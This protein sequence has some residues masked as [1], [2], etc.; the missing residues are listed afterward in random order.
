MALQAY[1]S[2][3]SALTRREQQKLQAVY[4]LHFFLSAYPGLMS[5]QRLA[6]GHQVLTTGNSKASSV[7]A[8]TWLKK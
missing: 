6:V 8:R 2:L 7:N 1:Y 5:D 3:K 4:R